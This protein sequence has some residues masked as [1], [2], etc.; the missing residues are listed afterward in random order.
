MLKT[1]L[2]LLLAIV[3]NS[4]AV[5][6]HHNLNVTITPDDSFIQ[7]TDILTIKQLKKEKSLVFKLHHALK[8]ENN[9][10][11]QLIKENVTGVDIGM[12][13]DNTANQNQ[14][15]LNEYK[16]SLPLNHTSDFE[17]VIKYQGKIESSIEQSAENYARGF[18][19]SSGIIWQ[20]GVYLAGSSYWLPYFNDEMLTYNLTTTLPKDWRVVTVGNRILDETRKNFHTDTWDSVTPQEEVFL[21]AAAFTEYSYS[22]GAVDAMAFLRTPDEGLANKYLETTAQYME[23]YRKLIGPYPYTK[24]ALVENFWET[25][26]GMPSFTLLGEKIIRFPFILHSSYPHELLH[27][28]WGNSVYIDFKNGNWCEGLTAYMA[29]HLIQEQR[30]Q[31]EKYRRSTL[32]KFTNFV[33]PKNDFPISQFTSRTDAAS[34]A[35]GYGKTLMFN[36]MLRRKVGDESFIKSYQA[37]NRNNKFKRAS[38][39]DIQQSFEQT[40]NQDLNWFFKQW[41]QRTGAPSLLLSDVSQKSIAGINNIGFTLKQIQTGKA[42]YLDVSL[43]LVTDD[44]TEYMSVQMNEKQQDFL[45]PVKSN[46][47]KILIDPHFDLFRILD[48]KESPPT[49]TRGYGADMTI[50]VLPDEKDTQFLIYQ[51]F[52]NK[53]I[54]GKQ[55]K[56]KLISQNDISTLP[57]NSSVMVLGSNNKFVKQ[58]NNELVQY[59]S[60]LSTKN[61]QLGKQQ[62]STINNSFFITVANPKNAKHTITFLSIGNKEAMA[63]L[64]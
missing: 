39:D 7:V 3:T 62:L 48:P 33:N 44:G 4:N 9:N 35:I 38:F 51:Q 41:I 29:D 26:Y 16:L 47:Q 59:Q 31:G 10:F 57:E 14:L 6:V 8:I 18:S 17:I 52:A 49:F 20:K 63:G 53:W 15:K 28:W 46:V 60:T 19:Q 34:E 61:I 21:I 32:Q 45:L 55:N 64:V 13:R 11:I 40:T 1:L 2:I 24:F 12:D 22:I 27:N 5:S 58:F 23:M 54:A 37:F 30:N 50:V 25:G 43:V 36:H 42:F 56:F